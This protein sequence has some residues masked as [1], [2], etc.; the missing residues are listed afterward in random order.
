MAIR[1]VDNTDKADIDSDLPPNRFI[2]ANDVSHAN[3]TNVSRFMEKE[4]SFEWLVDN[5][6]D[7]LK[8]K[9]E[10]LDIYYRLLTALIIV[11]FKSLK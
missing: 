4:N 7:Q 3:L 8:T 11:S 6:K 1:L 5:F 10:H 2:I 9:I